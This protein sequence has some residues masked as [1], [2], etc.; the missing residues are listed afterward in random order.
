MSRLHLAFKAYLKHIIT[1]DT[2]HYIFPD[3]QDI[4][5]ANS[6]TIYELSTYPIH[7]T[8]QFMGLRTHTYSRSTFYKIGS[9]PPF[10]TK[11]KGNGLIY[12]S[13]MWELITVLVNNI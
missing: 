13:L 10:C 1:C 11:N 8:K 9:T 7:F 6:Y 12:S 4:I 5:H 3:M 2:S